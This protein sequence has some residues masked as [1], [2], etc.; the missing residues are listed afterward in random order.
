MAIAAQRFQFLNRETNVPTIDFTELSDNQV[1]NLNVPELESSLNIGEKTEVLVAKLGESLTELKEMVESGVNAAAEGL[2]KALNE[3]MSALESLDL[4]GIVKDIFASLKALD[5]SGVR[6][7]FR[8][9]LKIGQ[10]FLCNNLDFL[11]LFML[12]FS[13]NKNILSGLVIALLLSWLDR[14]CKGFSKEDVDNSSPIERLEM[15]TKPKGILVNTTNALNK[16]TSSVASFKIAGQPLFI[17]QPIDIASGINSA[18]VNNINPFIENIRNA[19]L[20]YD[21][22]VDYS[23]AVDLELNR[24]VPSSQAY[25]NLLT[26]RAEINNV[27]TISE[28]RRERDLNYA[29][30]NDELGSFSR[31]LIDVDLSAIN[32]FSLTPIQKQLHETMKR[33]QTHLSNDSDFMNRNMN[34]GSYD[35]YNFDGFFN[36]LSLEETAYLLQSKPSE[37]SHRLHQIHPT[38]QVFLGA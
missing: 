10:S 26:L 3:V 5:L 6:D 30:V 27:P 9:M 7:F 4:P 32:T 34:T 1:Y 18:I 35:T 23:R 12:G 13:L 36:S 11:K 24:H 19:E 29:Y 25:K 14:F 15:L 16:F 17:P 37:T 8:D 20:S 2:Q 31:N 28:A 22:K 38:S 21:M 33:Y